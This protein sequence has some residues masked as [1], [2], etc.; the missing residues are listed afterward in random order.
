MLQVNCPTCF[1]HPHS[2]PSMNPYA[3]I[4]SAHLVHE[5]VF[6]AICVCE[7]HLPPAQIRLHAEKHEACSVTGWPSTTQPFLFADA[8]CASLKMT[9][10]GKQ[11]AS[12]AHA[13]AYKIFLELSCEISSCRCPSLTSEV[14]EQALRQKVPLCQTPVIFHVNRAVQTGLW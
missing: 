7:L 5:H 3:S 12:Y 4:C 14:L 10:S 2:T 9:T 6:I 8:I 1:M 11:S 13:Q